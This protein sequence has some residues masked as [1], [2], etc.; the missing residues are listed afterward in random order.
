[1]RYTV[2]LGAL[3]ALIICTAVSSAELILDKSKRD[4]IATVQR[5]DPVMAIAYKRARE[6][7]P[8]FLALVRSPRPSIKGFSV[9]VPIPYGSGNDAEFFWISPFEERDGKFRGRINNTPRLAKSVKLGQ[10]IAFEQE[11]IVD[12]LYH[13]NGKMVGNFTAC[14]LIKSEPPALQQAFMKHYGLSCDF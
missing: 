1:M 2:F 9:K 13:E 14:A 8:E 6:T 4:A 5:G 10:I 11:D 3:A 7:L 12:W